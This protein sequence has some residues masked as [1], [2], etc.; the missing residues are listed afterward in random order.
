MPYVVD[1]ACWSVQIYC[2]FPSDQH[3]QQAIKTDEMIDMRVRDKDVIETLDL[4]RRQ[5][6]NVAQIKQNCALFE[7]CLDVQGRVSGSPVDEGWVQERPHAKFLAHPRQETLRQI[8]TRAAVGIL[9]IGEG[10]ELRHLR[11]RRIVRHICGL[12]GSDASEHSV[13]LIY[14]NASETAGS[15][16]D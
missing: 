6:R 12:L 4:S 2:L 14:I 10:S 9:V 3:P 7:Q 15:H 5:I 1:E 16:H 13:L 8:I 11:W